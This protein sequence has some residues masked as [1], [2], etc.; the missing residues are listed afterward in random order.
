[1][2]KGEAGYVL[3]RYD[4]TIYIR[5]EDGDHFG[6]VDIVF[7]QEVRDLR[8]QVKLLRPEKNMITRKFTVQSVLTCELL[9]LNIVELDKMKIE[10]PEIFEELF[11][12][13]YRRLKREL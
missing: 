13:S 3:P 4:N 11:T 12:N 5:I 6:H 7:N 9:T 2:I 8:V 1:M 10:F